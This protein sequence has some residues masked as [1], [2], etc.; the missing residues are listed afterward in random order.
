MKTIANLLAALG[1]VAGFGFAVYAM[2]LTNQYDTSTLS[3]ATAV[4]SMATFNAV[5]ALVSFVFSGV[6]ILVA[7]RSKPVVNGV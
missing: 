6:C 1:V 3:A 4:F 2:W 7:L 5:M